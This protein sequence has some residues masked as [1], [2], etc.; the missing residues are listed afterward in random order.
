MSEQITDYSGTDNQ[1][2]SPA[3]RV[4]YAVVGLG[5]LTEAELYPA[6]HL[7]ARSKLTALV[8]GDREKA[9]V[10][11]RQLGLK[12]EDVYDY[13][14]FEELQHRADVQAVFIVLPNSL[15]REY[16]ER[17]AKIG[18]HVLCEKP[19]SVSV[20]DAEAMLSA[21]KA[22]DVLLM[23]AYRIQ[24]TPHH[25]AARELMQS[26]ELGRVKLMT[27][28]DVQTEPNEGQWRLKRKL[29]GG[30]SLLDVGLYC[31]NTARFLTGEE[32]YEVFA[33][34]HSTPGDERFEE[35]EESVSF[36]LR[37]PSGI[38]SS[39]F[40]SYGASRH[41]SVRVLADKA[42][43]LLDPAFDYTNLRLKKDT[44]TQVTELLIKEVDQFAL[45][46][47]HF[48]ACVSSGEQPYTPGEEGLQ[49]QR[50]MEA[51]YTSAREGRPVHLERFEGRDVFRG[52]APAQAERERS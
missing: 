20:Q 32:P 1:I 34:T 40:C 49:D 21:C 52:R 42:N 17:A 11:A 8:T 24:Y 51:I 5:E 14:H 12:D 33:Y 19:L 4:G 44:E 29:A 3:E 2:L 30:G 6:F 48:S 31:L 18:K 38:I 27:A 7:S 41:R 10:Q 50:I 26:G 22:A 16:T 46:L 39:N 35:V 13:D 47:D 36:T 43:L 23:T 9:L 25:Q 45:E 28:V 37:F 15:H